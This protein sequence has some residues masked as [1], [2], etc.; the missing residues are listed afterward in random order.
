MGKKDE[1]RDPAFLKAL[2]EGMDVDAAAASLFEDLPDNFTELED[3]E[4]GNEPQGDEDSTDSSDTDDDDDAD[5][6]DSDADDDAGGD[7]D[8]DDDDDASGED[9]DDGDDGDSD[10]EPDEDDDD[11]DE[12]EKHVVRVDGVDQEVTLEELKQGYSRTSDYTRKTQD[13][14]TARDAHAQEVADA[15]ARMAQYS[16]GLDALETALRA[17]RPEKPGEELRQKDPT[18]YNEAYAA[19]TASEDNLKQIGVEKKRVQ[20][21]GLADAQKNYDAALVKER[22]ALIRSIPEWS[23][24]EVMQKEKQG[25]ADFAKKKFGFTNEDLSQVLDHRVML[26]LRDSKKLHD[27]TTTGK[28]KLRTK[29]KKAKNLRPGTPKGKKGKKTSA[30]QRLARS[31][32]RLARTG[33]VDDAA[34]ALFDMEDVE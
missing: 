15:H 24:K 8:T 29:V 19:W 16:E 18:L 23:K 9:D 33:N 20:D 6:D 7:D 13:L 25:I 1:S 30:T 5:D 10:E 34:R 11:D 26:L 28:K 3:I 22:D 12:T 17:V 2:D 4:D 31:Q 21:E 14:A 27:M 32:K